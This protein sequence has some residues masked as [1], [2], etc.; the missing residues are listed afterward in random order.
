MKVLPED[1]HNVHLEI[2]SKAK[3][4]NATKA[5]IETHK[6]A[7]SIKKVN[8]EFFPEEQVATDFQAPGTK[9]LP[10]PEESNQASIKPSQTSG[11][12]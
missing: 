12:T 8:P 7:L 2:H 4:T 5:H 1:D 6:A 10:K 9:P 11:Q 3:E